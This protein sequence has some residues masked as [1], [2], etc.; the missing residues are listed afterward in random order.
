MF[1]ALIVTR[2]TV[3]ISTAW[4][5]SLPY[6]CIPI[7]ITYQ[8]GFWY[9]L[10]S[11]FVCEHIQSILKLWICLV[12][13]FWIERHH[14]SRSFLR[15][16]ASFRVRMWGCSIHFETLNMPPQRLLDPRTP[17]LR[18]LLFEVRNHLLLSLDEC[19]FDRV[20]M[21]HWHIWAYSSFV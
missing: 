18:I 12:N 5:E 9:V 16:C 3:L 20:K 1:P 2:A 13:G 6:P 19:G 14:C 11:A 4:L 10:R 15:M 8:T 21:R 7:T 17:L